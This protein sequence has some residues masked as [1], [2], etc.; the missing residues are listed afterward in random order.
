MR[1]CLSG[2]FSV[3]IASGSVVPIHSGSAD[4]GLAYK[5][6]KD[7]SSDSF[8]TVRVLEAEPSRTGRC[9]LVAELDDSQNSSSGIC[10][11]N[12]HAITSVGR[13]RVWFVQYCIRTTD[14]CV[15]K[16]SAIVSVWRSCE[17]TTYGVASEKHAIV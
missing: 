7:Q 3:S 6:V 12:L 16:G 15:V 4:L 14:H 5:A 2:E 17:S 8:D 10:S 11:D 9:L 13:R 1:Y